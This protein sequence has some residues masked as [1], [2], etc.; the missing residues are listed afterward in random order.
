LVLHNAGSLGWKLKGLDLIRL[1]RA[2]GFFSTILLGE[3]GAIYGDF[4]EQP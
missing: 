3:K 2:G 4:V 1:L